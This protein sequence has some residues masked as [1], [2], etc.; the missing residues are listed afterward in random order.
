MFPDTFDQ[1][2]SDVM[3]GFIVQCHYLE[4]MKGGGRAKL[5]E[6]AL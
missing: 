6:A 5:K 1:G 2:G 4:V 3:N